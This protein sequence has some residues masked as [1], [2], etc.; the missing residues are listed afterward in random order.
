MLFSPPL[1]AAAAASQIDEGSKYESRAACP[2]T[3]TGWYK[4]IPHAQLAVTY[5]LKRTFHQS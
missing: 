2:A 4:T 1:A 5:I 3:R